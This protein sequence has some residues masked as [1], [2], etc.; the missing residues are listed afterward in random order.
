MRIFPGPEICSVSLR[1]DNPG[2]QFSGV[3]P[4]ALIPHSPAW[5]HIYPISLTLMDFPR[6]ERGRRAARLADEH[7]GRL[8]A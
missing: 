6:A 5:S 2:V 4:A 1:A 3:K 7:L 8:P